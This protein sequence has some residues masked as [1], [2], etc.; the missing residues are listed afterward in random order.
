M[1]EQ[2]KGAALLSLVDAVVV[3][4]GMLHQV[5]SHMASFRASG[6]S[7]SDAPAPDEVL[8]GLLHEILESELDDLQQTQMATAAKVLDR[9]ASAIETQVF[10][11]PVPP[12]ESGS[13]TA[14]S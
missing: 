5:L 9:V 2:A 11:V 14:T 1:T 13:S 7:A 6:A 4:G 8:R 12:Y 3:N 10:L